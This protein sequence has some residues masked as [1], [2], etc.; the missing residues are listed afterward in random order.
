MHQAAGVVRI[1][2]NGRRKEAALTT[3]ATTDVENVV[4]RINVQGGNIVGTA[5]GDFPDAVLEI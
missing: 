4:D 5:E 2:S 3:G 1:K